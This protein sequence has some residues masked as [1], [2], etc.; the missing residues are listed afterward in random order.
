[1]YFQTGQGIFVPEWPKRE[2]VSIIGLILFGQNHL[3]VKTLCYKGFRYSE[4][5]QKIL[6]CLQVKRFPVPCQPSKRSCHPVRTPICPLFHPSGRR[7]LPSGRP[8]RPSIIRQDDVDFCPDPPLHREA[9][10]P[11]FI[12]LDVSAACPDTSQYSTKLQILSKFI[13][14]KIDATVRTTCIPV[15]TLFSL[16]QES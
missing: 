13:Y 14:G 15:W 8:D 5:F 11:A 6:H 12:R 3:Y 1:M 2:F 9:S 10:V 4:V 7:A 16:R